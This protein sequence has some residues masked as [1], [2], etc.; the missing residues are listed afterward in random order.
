MAAYLR[1]YSPS[2]SQPDSNR[3]APGQAQASSLSEG[4]PGSSWLPGASPLGFVVSVRFGQSW[5]H[6]GWD[7]ACDRAWAAWFRLRP[8]LPGV[9]L[10]L[11]FLPLY[12]SSHSAQPPASFSSSVTHTPVRSVT[13]ECCGV[14]AL[15]SK[16]NDRLGLSSRLLS[17][18]SGRPG[19]PFRAQFSP[20]TA[21]HRPAFLPQPPP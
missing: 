16:G 12:S 18:G 17:G 14:H 6:F 5:E 2:C 10:R 8:S 9:L 4:D 19:T 11:P 21:T 3:L 1:L 13:G 20:G 15:R 7:D